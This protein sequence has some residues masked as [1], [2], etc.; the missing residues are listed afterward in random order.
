MKVTLTKEAKQY[1][2]V[3]EM[4]AVKEVIACY[5]EDGT[6]AVEWAKMACN[7]IDNFTCE[8]IINAKAEIQRNTRIYNA[9]TKNS[10]FIDVTIIFTAYG[11]EY[12]STKDEITYEFIKCEA[13]LYDIFQISDDNHSEISSRFYIRRFPEQ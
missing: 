1:I 13:S 3:A 7:T 6:T 2:T 11:F 8:E 12:D 10:G 9:H 4:P 5:K